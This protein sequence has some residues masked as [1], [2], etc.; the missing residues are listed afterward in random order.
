[1][2]NDDLPPRCKEYSVL[3]FSPVR[4][5]SPLNFSVTT[6]RRNWG[7]VARWLHPPPCEGREYDWRLE[8]NGRYSI[9]TDPNNAVPLRRADHDGLLRCT[10]LVDWLGRGWLDF[11]RH[12]PG[13]MIIELGASKDPLTY[14]SV[15]RLC[16]NAQRALMASNGLVV[17]TC[18]D[19][20]MVIYIP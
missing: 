6:L 7:K 13:L 16:T 2:D 18:I 3:F 9:L 14:C 11:L 19:I 8:E 15:E 5:A 4:L 20:G 1:M 10:G 17:L 12:H